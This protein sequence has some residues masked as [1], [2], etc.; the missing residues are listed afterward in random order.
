[1][2]ITTGIGSNQRVEEERWIDINAA[3]TEGRKSRK[4]M[5]KPARKE[6]WANRSN[7]RKSLE[8]FLELLESSCE[9][10]R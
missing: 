1:V 4:W 9:A 3:T 8:V 6:L 7:C 10:T 2:G 5:L